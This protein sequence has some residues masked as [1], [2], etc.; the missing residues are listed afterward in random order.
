[1]ID[2]DVINGEIAVLEAKPM[3]Y[4]VAEK[5]ATL[6]VVK[7][8]AT[9]ATK[10]PVPELV[11]EDE[12]SIDSELGQAI[13]GKKMSQIMPVF[14]ELMETLQVLQPRIYDS[15]MRRIGNL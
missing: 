12:Y 3:T 10:T 9:I 13:K 4:Q 5:L 6:Y 1:M 11:T 2:L 7:D 15:V 14:N 8:H